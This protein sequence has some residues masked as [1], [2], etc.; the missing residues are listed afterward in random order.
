MYD[1][2]ILSA[3]NYPRLLVLLLSLFAT[4]VVIK[5]EFNCIIIFD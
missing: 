3:E 2:L 5:F 4:R 1:E